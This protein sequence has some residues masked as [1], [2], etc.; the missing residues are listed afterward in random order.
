MEK[1]SKCTVCSFHLKK[2][3]VSIPVRGFEPCPL[4]TV[5]G[6]SKREGT[7]LYRESPLGYLRGV[8]TLEQLF[9]DMALCAKTPELGGLK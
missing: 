9:F 5:F 2:N 6:Q 7:V 4:E 1:E 8:A 3:P